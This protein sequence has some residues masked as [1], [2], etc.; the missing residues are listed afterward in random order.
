MQAFT[1]VVW[2][3]SWSEPNLLEARFEIL[4]VGKQIYDEAPPHPNN[5][6]NNNNNNDNDKYC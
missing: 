5:N 1:I 4:I 6:N 2:I 3:S